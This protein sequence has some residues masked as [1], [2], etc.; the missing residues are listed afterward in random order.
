M[1][2][3][4]RLDELANIVGGGNISDCLVNA[5]ATLTGGVAA[6][7]LTGPGFVFGLIGTGVVAF[8]TGYSC[9]ALYYEGN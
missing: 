7:A 4:L 9:A 6:S 8:A 3:E 2:K 5:S 1:Y